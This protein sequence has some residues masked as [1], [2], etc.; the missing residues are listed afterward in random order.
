LLVSVLARAKA[1]TWHLLERVS[2]LICRR[3]QFISFISVFAVGAPAFTNSRLN[4]NSNSWLIAITAS[5]RALDDEDSFICPLCESSLSLLRRV[6]DDTR[7]LVIL[8]TCQW[9]DEY[10]GFVILTD[11]QK[12]DLNKF[13]KYRKRQPANLSSFNLVLFVNYTL[14]A[15]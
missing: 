12:E 8:V 1:V 14:I 9:C 10:H 4:V 2:F 7:E 3:A 6:H 15:L 11:L 5:A 13:S